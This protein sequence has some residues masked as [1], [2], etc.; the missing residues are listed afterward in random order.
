MNK[1]FENVKVLTFKIKHPIKR[2]KNKTFL[3]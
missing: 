1:L 2:S 3:Y